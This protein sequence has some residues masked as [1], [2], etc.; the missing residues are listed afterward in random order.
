MY[1]SETI[2]GKLY[3]S[4]YRKALPGRFLCHK[5]RGDGRQATGGAGTE[6]RSMRWAPSGAAGPGTARERA[7]RCSCTRGAHKRG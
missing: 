1:D 6:S 3:L 4:C 7:R 5:H 2:R